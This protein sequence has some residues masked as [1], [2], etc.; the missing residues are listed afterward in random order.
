MDVEWIS[1]GLEYFNLIFEVLRSTAGECWR[2]LAALQAKHP[3]L[4]GAQT[5]FSLTPVMVQ[6]RLMRPM[7]R[8]PKFR[9]TWTPRRVELAP[10]PLPRE[11]GVC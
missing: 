6:Q 11:N 2:Q 5:L 4:L 9:T 10:K 8:L 7:N 1:R 3:E